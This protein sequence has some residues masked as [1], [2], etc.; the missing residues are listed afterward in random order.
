MPESELFKVVLQGG[1]LG[2]W[3]FFGWWCLAR[4]VPLLKEI[5]ERQATTSQKMVSE[6]SADLK[7]CSDKQNQCHLEACRALADGHRNVVKELAAQCREER[8]ELLALI[9]LDRSA[10]AM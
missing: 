10:K 1:M 3:C 8:K 2:L 4:G 9:H 6:L 7:H 5:M